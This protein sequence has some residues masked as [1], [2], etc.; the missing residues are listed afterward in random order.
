MEGK[1][2]NGSQLELT[3]QS[4]E[5]TLPDDRWTGTTLGKY[6]IIR[7]L[8]KGGMGVVYEAIDPVLQ[9]SVAVKVLREGIATRPESVRKFLREAR[10]A[11][12]LN[13]PN[14]VHIYEADQEKEMCYLVMELMEGGSAHD[15]IQKWG[16]FGWV[17]ATQVM[18]D[19]CRG[20]AAVHAAGL[21][22]RDI[23]PSNIMRAAN[24]TVKVADFGLALPSANPV[25][26][27]PYSHVVGTPLYMSPE[28][29]RG[30]KLDSRSDVYALGATYYT[31]LTG[32]PPFEG[33]TPL[34]IMQGHCANPIP[35]PRTITPNMPKAC[36][37]LISRTLAKNA[38]DRPDGAAALLHELEYIFALASHPEMPALDWATVGAPALA[39]TAV[40]QQTP[41]S[42]RK[43][44]NT[45]IWFVVICLILMGVAYG[46]GR[47]YTRTPVFANNAASMAA[48]FAEPRNTQ[49]VD[50]TNPP[51][52]LRYDAK[53]PVTTIAFDS[54]GKEFLSW[55]TESGGVRI[56][57]LWGV[58]KEPVTATPKAG[59]KNSS[60]QQV[61]YSPDGRYWASLFEGKLHF[62]EANLPKMAFADAEL[63]KVPNCD[64]I[65]F[66]FH[67]SKPLIALAVKDTIKDAGQTTGGIV[68]R[69]LDG[70]AHDI[71]QHGQ[72][73]LILK[74]L[75]FSR[76]GKNLVGGQETGTVRTWHLKFTNGKNGKEQAVVSDPPTAGIGNSPVITPIPIGDDQFVVA[77][78]QRVFRFDPE[79]GATVGPALFIAPEGDVIAIALFPNE[80]LLACTTGNAVTVIDLENSKTIRTFT[81]G[82]GDIT[83]M[84]LRA[85]GLLMAVGTNKDK[86][87]VWKTE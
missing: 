63:E 49:P 3:V 28:Q 43:A 8:G 11:A 61:G 15:R 55:G 66:A 27:T 6:Q 13:H 45:R 21:I 24:G 17:E 79:S 18:L 82:V 19:A 41:P 14:V 30:Q 9:R 68:L 44:S 7:R 34:D 16:P 36:F 40:A 73:G 29:C 12:R 59:I 25:D 51:P 37:D 67:P 52:V 50:T 83:A 62:Y 65:A 23:K 10:A 75:A 33:E 46:L 38:N 56:I 39:D 80:K 74:S 20:V 31:L 2:S 71:K 22:H 84:A 76:D 1:T 4:P 57:P 85:D 87:I 77:C 53:A 54:K 81:S 47:Y 42:V 48:L 32:R 60:I 86:V 35:D 64:I 78:G 26:R 70:R 58:T 5:G 69:W 72:Q